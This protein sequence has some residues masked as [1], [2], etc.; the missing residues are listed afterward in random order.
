MIEL[1]SLLSN[2]RTS[3]NPGI[4]G[5]YCSTNNKLYIGKSS[6]IA[7]RWIYHKYRLNKGIHPNKHLLSAWKKFGQK[8]FV[9]LVIEE[10]PIDELSQKEVFYINSFETKNSL[11]GFNKKDSDGWPL[12]QPLPEETR[13]KISSALKGQKRSTETK[14]LMSLSQLGK[15]HSEESKKKMSLARV[16]EKNPNYGK[17]MSEEQKRKISI[18]KKG[19]KHSEETKE[20]MRRAKLKAS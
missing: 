15:T 5:I 4:Y 12:G 3:K 8:V 2:P 10:C 18:A 20:K 19:K 14:I 9:F 7:K 1:T 6:N 17:K 16:G 13:K 11:K